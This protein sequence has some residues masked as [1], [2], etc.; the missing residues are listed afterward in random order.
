[1]SDSALARRVLVEDLAIV[2]LVLESYK[3]VM[4]RSRNEREAFE[5]AV[6]IYRAQSSDLPEEEARRAVANILCGKQTTG[7]RNNFSELPLNRDSLL[8]LA[9]E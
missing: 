6:R 4:A 2:G 3:A 5:T 9:G 7:E 1:M 8:H